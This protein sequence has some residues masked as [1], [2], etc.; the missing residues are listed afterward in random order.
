[1]TVLQ[2]SE[3]GIC[4]WRG[5]PERIWCPA[6]GSVA[7]K[8]APEQSGVV[9]DMTVL[10]RAVGRKLE[11]PA[12]AGTVRLD[13]GGRVVARLLDAVPGQRV[14]LSVE[15]GAPIARPSGS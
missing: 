9:E 12:R 4:G 5:F 3:C 15:D 13:G 10:E 1:M 14:L 11:T 8:A 2:V 7:I 6:C